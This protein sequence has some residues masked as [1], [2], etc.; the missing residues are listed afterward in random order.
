M[1][2]LHLIRKADDHYPAKIIAE[3]LADPQHE[4]RIVFLQDAVLRPTPFDAE[5]FAL[6]E[7]C[8]ARGVS[9]GIPTI[10][11]DDLTDMIFDSDRVLS[12]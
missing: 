2:L 4:V 7:D 1:K 11:Y 8:A 3:H 5:R 6:D 12:W 9:S 10:S